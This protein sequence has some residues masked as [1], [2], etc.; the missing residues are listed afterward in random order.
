MMTAIRRLALLLGSLALLAACGDPTDP[1]SAEETIMGPS[2]SPSG[3]APAGVV[4][5]AAADLAVTLEVDLTEVEVVAV[6]EVTWRDGSRGCA[7]P[8]MS[9][10][11]ALVDGSRITLRVGRSHLRVPLRR[12]P[13]AHP[14][15]EADRVGTQR[16]GGG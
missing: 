14:L 9:Y 4:G 16:A 6:E 1:P 5:A 8:G 2:P 3:S 11:Q 13:A 15:Q 7:L 10:T 12:E